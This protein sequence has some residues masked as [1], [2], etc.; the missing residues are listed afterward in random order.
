MSRPRGPLVGLGRWLISLVPT[1]DRNRQGILG[2]LDE[3]YADKLDA[4]RGFTADVWYLEEAV[5]AALRLGVRSLRGSGTGA[6]LLD[7]KLGARMLRKQPMLTIVAL[8]A[9]GIGIPLTLMPAHALFSIT[10]P[11]PF[12]EGERLAGIR[13]WDLDANRRSPGSLRDFEVWRQELTNFEAIGA[14]RVESWNVHSEDGRAEPVSGAV[15]S[16]SS[17][18]IVRV[19]P[20]LG[21]TLEAA[22]A[23][24]GAPDV[25]VI[26]AALW[27]SR[28]GNDP[29]IVGKT[30]RVGGTPHT[31]VGV[32]PER[33]A[34]PLYEQIWLPLRDNPADYLGGGEPYLEVFGRLA[35]GVSMDQAGA[36][37]EAVSQ[38][39]SA[40]YT[41]PEAR[42]LSQ[43]VTMPVWASPAIE[44][45]TTDPFVYLAQLIFV[46]LLMIVCGNVGIMILA[47]TA[48]RSA[49]IAVRTALGASRRRIVSQ[50]FVEALVLALLATG[51]GLLVADR[52]ASRLRPL[53]REIP[54]WVDLGIGWRTAL[55]A[56]GLGIVS[57]AV[58]SVIPALRATGRS[59]QY[60]LQRY[61][62]R[63]SIV[64]FGAG[65][66]ALIVVEV[67]LA[68]AALSWGAT[69]VGT[70]LLTSDEM[71][72]E[73]ERYVT[74]QLRVPQAGAIRGPTPRFDDSL[75]N[76][77]GTTQMELKHRIQSEPGVLSV[78]M[79]S[80]LPGTQHRRTR[81][82]V[83]GDV[84]GSPPP[85]V[86]E[87]MV[88]VDFFRD[89]GHPIL[90]GR[91]FIR[92]DI[93]EEPGED[94]NAVIVNTTFVE[95]V[96][97]GRSPV[98]MRIQRPPRGD[99]PGPWYEIVGVVGPF[100][101]NPLNPARD[102]G[103]YH[104]VG[105]GGFYP[106]NY[107]IDVGGDGADFVPRLR[108]IAAEVDPVAMIEHAMPLSEVTN[109]M[110]A[111]LRFVALALVFIAGVAVFL[112]TAGLYAL[113]SFT[114]AQRRR[115]I[116]IRTAL[117]AHPR[118][119]VFTIV[120][121][122]AIQLAAG[123]VLGAAFGAVLLGNEYQ[124]DQLFQPVKLPAV[125]T[126]VV[127]TLLVGMIA[128][129]VPTLRGLRIQP[130]EALQEG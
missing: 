100:G 5:V 107:V 88:D 116:G 62:G 81:F 1:S 10:A 106:V 23:V 12:D 121:R 91:D 54:P 126:V 19:P 42:L 27:E 70:T 25:V 58:A 117:G 31:V 47:R 113:I 64:G 24:I 43:V 73:F 15:V 115:E 7:I 48:N 59:V 122:A 65:S 40:E 111:E 8:L 102:A 77:V 87:G 85:L 3:L 13:I 79:T 118:S 99:E 20:L 112:P 80:D 37:V 11:F 16:P 84:S 41:G 83:E 119:I 34:F 124:S 86:F 96:L 93:P 63:G 95:E 6:S 89:M 56:L 110:M 66:T 36:E 53:W 18:D 78:A 72:I 49:E 60:N 44:R 101:M 129:L 39:I 128:C 105:A 67:A 109:G 51:M 26:G 9:L 103:V 38:R 123:V 104:P 69:F 71:G 50:L 52:Y 127:G 97:G 114:V 75:S 35:D 33:F 76:R 14:I 108:A 57:A 55:L 17:F 90:A 120:R 74:A 82:R 46:G 32:M 61:A 94:R 28:L 125:T 2:D 21:R 92:G 68:V 98:G 45:I 4:G 130:T 30:I 29:E 22:D